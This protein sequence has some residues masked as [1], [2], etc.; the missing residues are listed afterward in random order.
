MKFIFYGT[1][2]LL[3]ALSTFL[4][5]SNSIHNQ[6]FSDIAIL[7]KDIE[8]GMQCDSV[9]SIFED[10]R[11]SSPSKIFIKKENVSSTPEWQHIIGL[12]ST[13]SVNDLSTPFDP[14]NYYVFC[15]NSGMVL[16]TYL[17]GD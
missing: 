2:G 10:Y 4:F 8:I 9:H 12:A 17:V 3:V 16:S 6:Y 5:Y 13:I 14:I 7:D 15:S 1:L 11:I